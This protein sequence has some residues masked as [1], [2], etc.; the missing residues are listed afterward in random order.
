MA[1][2][3][4]ALH[5]ISRRPVGVDEI[6]YEAFVDP[7]G[8][9]RWDPNFLDAYPDLTP[10]KTGICFAGRFG[11]SVTDWG[12]R[13]SAGTP[14]ATHSQLMVEIAGCR[15]RFCSLSWAIQAQRPR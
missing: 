2:L 8:Y 5:E 9:V 14:A 1:N 6:P 15:C 11:L 7:L 10:L 13:A 4:A 12:Y 3:C